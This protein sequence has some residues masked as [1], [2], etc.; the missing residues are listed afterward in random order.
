MPLY[1][2]ACPTCATR[3]ESLQR[4]FREKASCPSCGTPEVE[5]LLSTFAMSSGS[6]GGGRDV[7]PAPRS[8]GGGSCC[9]GGCGC[10]H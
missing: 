2:Y 9:G 5:R 6:A 4:S 10:A 8:M 1:E 3:F 7:G